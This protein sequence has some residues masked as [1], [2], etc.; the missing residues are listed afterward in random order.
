[1]SN[2]W[3]KRTSIAANESQIHS[4][5]NQI[6]ASTKSFFTNMNWF[7]RFPRPASRLDVLCLEMLFCRPQLEPVIIGVSGA[8]LKPDCPFWPLTPY[9]NKAFCCTQLQLTRYFLIWNHYGNHINGYLLKS[10]QT[11]SLS[12]CP[13]SLTSTL[14]PPF[15][16]PYL[17]SHLHN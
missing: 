14:I 8:I 2:Q 13:N 10:Q 7:K 1:M 11:S 16:C 15:D 4:H 5:N 3:L 12:S 9:M 6:H 17:A